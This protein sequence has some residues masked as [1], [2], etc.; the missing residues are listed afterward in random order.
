MIYSLKEYQRDAVDELKGFFELYFRSSTRKEIVFK[1]PTG[2][3][4][5]FMASSLMEELAS[6]NSDINFCIMWACP[7]K[8]ELRY[9]RCHRQR[10]VRQCCQQEHPGRRLRY[11]RLQL[12]RRGLAQAGGVLL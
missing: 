5:T 10:T 3:G 9:H 4:K 12:H 2:S 1:A 8:G 11:A 6:E 7:G